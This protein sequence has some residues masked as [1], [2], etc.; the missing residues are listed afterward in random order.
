M[1]D[2]VQLRFGVGSPAIQPSAT[3]TVQADVNSTADVIIS[4]QQT[5]GFAEAVRISS[6]GNVGIATSNPTSTLTVNGVISTLQG[7][8]QYPD[9]T[10]QSSAKISS[11]N[12]ATAYANLSA[13]GVLTLSGL[14]QIPP[15]TKNPGDP[16]SLGQICWDDNYI[17]VYTNSGWKSSA[18][19]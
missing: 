11:L 10:L 16:G 4:T 3:I 1:G 18:L 7:G 14:L 2:A 15:A 8:V 5:G 9:G 17:Y 6:A 12:N 19:S 13:A